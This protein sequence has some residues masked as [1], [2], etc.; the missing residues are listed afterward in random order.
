MCIRPPA[1]LPA[2]HLQHGIT[3]ASVC[4][5]CCCNRKASNGTSAPREKKDAAPFKTVDSVGRSA[6]DV[7]E[8]SDCYELWAGRGLIG[9][10]EGAQQHQ[11]LSAGWRKLG[12]EAQQQ[13]CTAVLKPQLLMPACL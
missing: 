4:V 11:A 7:L 12:G 8:T 6:F 13:P 1:H 5:T 10:C 9:R 3:V 2:L